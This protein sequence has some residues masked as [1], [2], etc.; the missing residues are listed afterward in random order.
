M[1]AARYER[2]HVVL[3]FSSEKS[4][5]EKNEC[6]GWVRVIAARTSNNHMFMT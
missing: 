3:V 2:E 5:I 6:V 1:D 4:L